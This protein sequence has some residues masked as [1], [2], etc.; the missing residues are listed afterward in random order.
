MSRRGNQS[1]SN[2]PSHSLAPFLLSEVKIVVV[3]VIMVA[4]NS[5]STAAP[6][7]VVVVVPRQSQRPRFLPRRDLLV[8]SLSSAVE[9]QLILMMST[10]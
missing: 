10:R 9:K 2:R 3:V 8:E 1:D 4:V 5:P 7:H 6:P